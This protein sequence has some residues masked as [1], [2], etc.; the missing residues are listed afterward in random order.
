MLETVIIAAVVAGFGTFVVRSRIRG[1]SRFSKVE[2]SWNNTLLSFARDNGLEGL[3]LEFKT[4]TDIKKKSN[5]KGKVSFIAPSIDK[6]YDLIDTIVQQGYSFG[7]HVHHGSSEFFYVLSGK[8]KIAECKNDPKDCL[9]KCG[10]L[11]GLYTGE[12]Y[13]EDNTVHILK[14]GENLFIPASKF[15]TFDAL[16]DSRV[17]VVTLPPISE[18]HHKKAV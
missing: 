9:K 13:N 15:H 7:P 12:P 8:I 16:E 6:G 10:N 14:A 17:I 5:D 18:V 2:S 11:C 1:E 4:P 3:D